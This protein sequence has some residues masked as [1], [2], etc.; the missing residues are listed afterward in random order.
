MKMLNYEH[1]RTVGKLFALGLKH[2]L[3]LNVS[4]DSSFTKQLTGQSLDIK[5]VQSCD[6]QVQH[7][8]IVEVTHTA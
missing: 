4:L 5:D 2:N 7:Q 1:F 8:L 3:V 6:F